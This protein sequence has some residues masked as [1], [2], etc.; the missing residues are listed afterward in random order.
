MAID[1]EAKISVSY[2][3]DDFLS[4][5]NIQLGLLRLDQLHPVVSG[6]KWFKLKRN[7][8]FA[9]EQG[10]EGL[11]TFGGSHSNHLIATAA[12]AKA[13]HLQSTGLVRGLHAEAHLPE[14]LRN[15]LEEGMAL[16]YLSREEYSRKQDPDFLSYWQQLYPDFYIVPEGGNNVLGAEG[17]AE[18]SSYIPEAANLV[19]LPVGTGTTFTGIRQSLPAAKTMLGF[20]GMK[21]GEYLQ[22]IIQE[23]LQEHAQEHLGPWHITAE[24]H[25]G[26]F[27]RHTPQLIQFINSFYQKQGIGLDFVYTAKMMF[28]LYELIAQNRIENGSH[29]IALH[30]GGLQGNNS[31]KHLL[32]MHNS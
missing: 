31:I 27:A 10:K 12:A 25:F 15:C 1:L 3:E 19:A 6:N 2:L 8:Q 16:H 17:A 9:L 32:S 11:L 14:T 5:K 29:I 7:I 13:Y 24:Y 20:C 26:G 18:I 22:P 28:G 4:R 21:G 30:T 23:H